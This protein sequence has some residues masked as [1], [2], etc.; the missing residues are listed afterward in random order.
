VTVKISSTTQGSNFQPIGI[1]NNDAAGVSISNSRVEVNSPNTGAFGGQFQSGRIRDS[2]F[3]VNSA[4]GGAVGIL[5]SNQMTLDNVTIN[6]SSDVSAI[7]FEY[8]TI[9]SNAQ[10]STIRNSSITAVGS[11]G[12]GVYMGR[13]L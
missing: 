1:I 2:V 6:A 9:F 4:N 11:T 3:N 13:G 5:N 8:L 10:Q 12:Y 7:G